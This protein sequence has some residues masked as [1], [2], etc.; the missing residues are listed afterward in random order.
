MMCFDSYEDR[1]YKEFDPRSKI[2]TGAVLVVP[3]T[4]NYRNLHLKRFHVI[5]L[6]LFRIMRCDFDRYQI[7]QK[8]ATDDEKDDRKKMNSVC[9]LSRDL[10][11]S[12]AIY[13]EG[14]TM[15]GNIVRV[16]LIFIWIKIYSHKGGIE[17]FL[18]LVST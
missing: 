4:H 13:F 16:L 6:I 8:C 18:S 15:V 2:I 11:I 10:N 12:N 7:E 3:C 9:D 5:F 17:C 1:G 14:A